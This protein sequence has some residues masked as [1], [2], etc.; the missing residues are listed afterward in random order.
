[1]IGPAEF[2]GRPEHSQHIMVVGRRCDRL[3]VDHEGLADILADHGTTE[4]QEGN[5]EQ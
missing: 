3:Q 1:M 5:A 2:V 4:R